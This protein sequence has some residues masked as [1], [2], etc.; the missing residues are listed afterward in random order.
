MN[1]R[2]KNIPLKRTFKFLK[3]HI[4]P[5]L[6]LKKIKKKDKKAG[7]FFSVKKVKKHRATLRL[8]LSRFLS[9]YSNYLISPALGRDTK[10]K[11]TPKKKREILGKRVSHSS[12][13]PLFLSAFSIDRLILVSTTNTVK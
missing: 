7:S 13:L 10:K 11:K 1:A 3:Y 9:L 5:L 2:E 12:Y 4:C 8:S 6:S